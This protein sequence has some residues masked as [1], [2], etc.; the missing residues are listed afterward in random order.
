M[1]AQYRL[2]DLLIF[3]I[4]LP[5]TLFV[6]IGAPSPEGPLCRQIAGGNVLYHSVRRAAWHTT[7]QRQDEVLMVV[8]LK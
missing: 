6:Y 5:V 2:Y 4:I 8:L 3:D 7:L 1:Y